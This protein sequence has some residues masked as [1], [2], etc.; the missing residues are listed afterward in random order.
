MMS[1]NVFTRSKYYSFYGWEKRWYLVTPSLAYFQLQFQNKC[2]NQFLQT[3]SFPI[4][5]HRIASARP[6][7][8]N[9]VSD[10]VTTLTTSSLG[11]RLTISYQKH[12]GTNLSTSEST[13]TLF[14]P[15]DSTHLFSMCP[16]FCILDER[17]W[18]AKSTKE[19]QVK[20]IIPCPGE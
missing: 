15:F 3:H 9:I 13:M 17:S 20:L 1:E 8:S 7:Q 18:Y 12:I 4:R 11:S 2:I 19:H 14:R 16:T 10:Q 5:N 6:S